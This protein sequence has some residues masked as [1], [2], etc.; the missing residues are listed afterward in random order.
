MT[1]LSIDSSDDPE[2]E[3]WIQELLLAIAQ[4]L[5]PPRTLLDRKEIRLILEREMSAL[6]MTPPTNETC[7]GKVSLRCN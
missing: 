6:V 4:S 2:L 1:I 5:S 7:E 3:T